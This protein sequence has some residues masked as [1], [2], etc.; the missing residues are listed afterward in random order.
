V[1]DLLPLAIAL[2]VAGGALL[3]V[4]SRNR[5]RLTG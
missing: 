5:R 1:V 2:V 3:T 4:R